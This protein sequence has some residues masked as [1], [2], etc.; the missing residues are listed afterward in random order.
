MFA[1]I[2]INFSDSQL[3][4]W[5]TQNWPLSLLYCLQDEMQGR[6]QYA[7]LYLVFIVGA[8]ALK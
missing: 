8:Y 7:V 5:I 1:D 4:S 6:V 2:S 3:N